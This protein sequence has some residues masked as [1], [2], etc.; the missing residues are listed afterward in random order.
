MLKLP[1][2]TLI[3]VSGLLA[4]GLLLVALTGENVSSS[5]DP[6]TIITVPRLSAAMPTVPA[7][8]S[9]LS[10]PSQH[11]AATPTPQPTKAP[12][13]APAQPANSPPGAPESVPGLVKVTEVPC[14]TPVSTAYNASDIAYETD[15]AQA[16]ATEVVAAPAEVVQTAENTSPAG[17]LVLAIVAI[18]GIFL[19][20]YSLTSMIRRQK[21]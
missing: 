17:W 4:A 5:M 20:T 7:V 12:Q 13:Q 16:P 3:T 15:E 19:L 14:P 10:V 6:L 8:P 9:L 21:K 11:Q 18:A 1:T 2:A